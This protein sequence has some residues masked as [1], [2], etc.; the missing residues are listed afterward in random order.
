MSIT[1]YFADWF[2][3]KCPH[4]DRDVLADI[5]SG[6]LKDQRVQYCRRCGSYRFVRVIGPAAARVGEWERPR[7]LWSHV[8]GKP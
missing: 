7:P 5:H 2:I 3:R 4:D 6:D 1:N 8:G